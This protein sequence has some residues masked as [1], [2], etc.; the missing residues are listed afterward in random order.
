MLE[1]Y[2]F[3]IIL[4]EKQNNNKTVQ[5]TNSLILNTYIKITFINKIK[6]GDV[7]S[8]AHNM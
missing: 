3:I 8:P 5:L 7:R 1:N 2:R 4:I 6:M